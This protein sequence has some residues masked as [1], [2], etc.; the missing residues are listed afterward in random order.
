MAISVDSTT[1]LNL[2]D[3]AEA[4]T[5]WSFSGITKTST[6]SAS[7]EGTNC[8]GGQVANNSY[9]YAWHTHGSSV[10]MTTAGNE[11]VYIWVNSV[12]AGTYA[13]N[14]WMVLIGDGT[15]RRAYRVGGSDVVPFS[16]KGWYCLMLDT[17][18][19]P[20]TYQQVAGGAPTL[21]AI[22]QFGFG[23]YN[24]VAPSGNALNV[25]VDVV[26]YGSGIVVTS[27]ATDDISL[28]D[29]AAE[30][31]SSTTGKAYGI[32][33][34]IQP[35]VYGIQGDILW[36]DTAGNSIDWKETDAIVIFEDRVEGTGTNTKFQ[37]SGQ[38][39]ATGTFRVELGI[40]VASGD[41]ETGR[42]GVT[43]FS[44]NPTD[45]PIDFDFSDSDIED[46][47][48]YGCAFTNMRGGTIAFSADAT[49]GVSHHL[50]GCNFSGCSQVDTGRTVV[51]NCGFASTGDTTSA[52]LWNANINVKN[53]DFIGNTVGA[54]IEHPEVSSSGFTYDN[55]LF[56][57]N[58]YDIE[59]S[60][61]AAT[62][63][64]GSFV[65]GRGYKILTVGSTDYTLIGAADNNIGTKF[66]ATGVGSGTGTATEVLL[67]NATN[68]ANPSAAKA[69]NSGTNSDTLVQNAVILYVKVQ[70]EDRQPI[71]D[72]QT[73]IYYVASP[74]M[75]LMNEDT[76]V[77]GV[78]QETYNFG[79]TDVDVVVKARKSDEL[80]NPR[81]Q[82][83][84]AIQTITSDGLNLTVTLRETSLPI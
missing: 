24:V 31:F 56:S 64:A 26:R 47:F 12:G 46:V 13:Q 76:L 27:G 36:G 5:G 67:I 40:A 34:E 19:L 17:A 32:V 59:N 73:S 50:S 11:R 79:G 49:N 42:S 35:G 84:S 29:V 20:T 61:N 62:I 39:S 70:D 22:T 53:T 77:T 3:A 78:A 57:G 38:H 74:F 2:I 45:Q 72:V 21:T 43:F 8:V 4:T 16:V 75:E 52:L 41:D 44:A 71:Q 83:Y 33:R 81:Y 14:G 55:M 63:N 10:N 30:D 7:R 48:L 28:A 54:A 69:N 37:F 51:R 15:N 60:D 82:A 58:T 23:I 9:G 80:D 1:N 6:S 65:V 25:F 68:G 66:E 18:N